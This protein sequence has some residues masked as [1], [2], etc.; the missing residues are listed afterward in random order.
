RWFY[1]G[2]IVGGEKTSTAIFHIEGMRPV[3]DFTATPKY[4]LDVNAAQIIAL[5][6]CCHRDKS[7]PDVVH[8]NRWKPIEGCSVSRSKNDSARAQEQ[9]SQLTIEGTACLDECCQIN[10]RFG[11]KAD[12]RWLLGPC[13]LHPR[14]RTLAG[15]PRYVRFVP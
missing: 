9:S 10:V 15:R 4:F 8:S 11:S 13:P 14:K 5:E 12:I 2:E 6:I 7:C 1:S 3:T